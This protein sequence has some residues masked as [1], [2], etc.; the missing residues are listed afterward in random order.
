MGRTKSIGVMEENTD[1]QNSILFM[2]TGTKL[3]Q[4]EYGVG[5]SKRRSEVVWQ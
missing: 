1:F 4:S 3:A 2:I 5:S